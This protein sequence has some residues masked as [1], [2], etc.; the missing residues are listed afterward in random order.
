MQDELFDVIGF[1]II[2]D[3]TIRLKF[4]DGS[5]QV[6]NFEAILYG[7]LFEPLRDLQLFNQVALNAELGTLVWPNGADIDPTVLHDWPDQVAA[8]VERRKKQFLVVS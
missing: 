3:Y 5:E 2:S 7:P 8:I 1:E 4:D 6:I